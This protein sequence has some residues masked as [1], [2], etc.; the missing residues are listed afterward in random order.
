MMMWYVHEFS[1]FG[2]LF[3]GLMMFLFWG[4]L[5]AFA[6]III[7]RIFGHDQPRVHQAGS[8]TAQEI[9]DQRYVR[10]EINR[11]QYE[12]MKADLRQ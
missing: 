8:I 10:G 7:K 12:Q 3:G 11:D 9:L 6:A 4:G 2:M 5:V 1:W